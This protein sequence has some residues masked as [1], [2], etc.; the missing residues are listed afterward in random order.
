MKR[1]LVSVLCVFALVATLWAN[2]T[3]ETTESPNVQ[4]LPQPTSEKKSDKPKYIEDNPESITGT[5]RFYTAFK[6]S[7]GMDD[8]IAEF[9]KI[10]PNIK[11]ELNAY[12]NGSDGNIGIDTQLIAGGSIDV[13]HTF[14]LPNTRRRW[15]NDLFLDLTDY[16]SKDNLDVKKEWGTDRYKYNNRYYSVPMGGLAYYIAINMDDWHKAGYTDL[17]KEWTWDEYLEASRKMTSGE[18]Q[19]KV[20]GGSDNHP[21]VYVSYPERQVKGYDAYYKDDGTSDFDNPEYLKALYRKIDAEKEGIWFPSKTYV[22]DKINHQTTYC[23]HQVASVVSNNLVR[24]L[25]DTKKYPVSWVTG[26]APYPVEEKGQVNHLG[27]VVTFSHLAITKDCKNVPAAYAFLKFFATYGGIYLVPAGH[28]PTWTGTDLDNAINVIFGSKEN[29]EKIVDV[30]SLLNTLFHFSEDAYYETN[31]TG[32][33]DVESLLI[34]YTLD[35]VSGKKTPEEAMKELKIQAD[36]A[37]K[38][39]E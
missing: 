27:S 11:I 22:F 1:K 16:L 38:D 37:I 35:A 33:S 32:I 8:M 2:G 19:T 7:A 4:T 12:S 23:G 29:A 5:V 36:K 10:Y 3:V 13:L 39:A 26:F 14:G 17:P 20:Y 24:F 25:R 21:I 28:M 18:G 6:G 30:P 31:S 34:D 9:N 15:E